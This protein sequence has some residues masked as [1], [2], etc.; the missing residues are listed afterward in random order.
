MCYTFKAFVGPMIYST[1]HTQQFVLL[2]Q[3]KYIMY[4]AATIQES[5]V[6]SLKR[7]DISYSKPQEDI[8]NFII[9]PKNLEEIVPLKSLFVLFPYLDRLPRY[10]DSKTTKDPRMGWSVTYIFSWK[11]CSKNRVCYLSGSWHVLMP[12]RRC[13]TE[14]FE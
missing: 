13:A 10:N 5:R 8:N 1:L 7:F 11:L 2:S 4:N 3:V 6:L 12:M 9:E 14:K